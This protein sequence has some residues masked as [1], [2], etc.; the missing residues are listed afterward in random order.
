VYITDPNPSPANGNKWWWDGSYH[1][2]E[3]VGVDNSG[4]QTQIVFADPDNTIYAPNSQDGMAVQRTDNSF[5]QYLN[6]N[7]PAAGASNNYNRSYTTNDP[8][9]VGTGWANVGANQYYQEAAVGATGNIT[10]GIYAGC[11]ISAIYAITPEP[12]ALLL[13]GA[14]LVSL[15]LYAW[16][17]RRAMPG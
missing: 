16:R 15:L 10:S 17:R 7:W 8:L 4:G 5:G 1:V 6:A 12:S 9:P 3:G 2:L 13:L 11:T 14:G